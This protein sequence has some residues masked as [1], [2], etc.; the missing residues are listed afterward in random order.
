MVNCPFINNCRSK[1][2]ACQSCKH[3]RKKEDHYEPERP[4]K[5]YSIYT[6]RW[7]SAD[8]PCLVEEF[9]KRN[10]NKK[11]CWIS[12]PCPRCTPRY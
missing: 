1:G 12:C 11:A 4:W 2:I 6:R 7:R 10:P 5:P 9:F 3:N 8:Q